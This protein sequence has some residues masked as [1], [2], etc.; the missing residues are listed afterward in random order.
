MAIIG[1]QKQ[2]DAHVQRMLDEEAQL[3]D[4]LQKLSTFITGNSRF[5][6]LP[7]VDQDLMAA[8]MFAMQAYASILNTRLRMATQVGVTIPPEVED[9]KMQAAIDAREEADEEGVTR[10][11]KDTD[12]RK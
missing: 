5:E 11:I 7:A 8:Q 6:Q 10:L 1:I 12:W 2:V 4:R 9:A 3:A